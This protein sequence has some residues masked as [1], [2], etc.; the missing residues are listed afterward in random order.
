MQLILGLWG[1]TDKN[2][3]DE[4]AADGCGKSDN[5]DEQSASHI[6]HSLFPNSVD[7]ASAGGAPKGADDAASAR[8]LGKAAPA[9]PTINAA[10][11]PTGERNGPG[12][13]AKRRPLI[14]RGSWTVD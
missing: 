3:P 4:D 13:R 1:M 10:T 7:G 9:T 5:G 11:T 2:A 14:G 12:Q 6:L 8:P